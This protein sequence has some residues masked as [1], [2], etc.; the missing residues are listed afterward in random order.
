MLNRS[1]ARCVDARA[2]GA[3]EGTRVVLRHHTPAVHWLSKQATRCAGLLGLRA[4]AALA[5][6]GSTAAVGQLTNV[7]TLRR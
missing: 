7:R 1:R 4:A 5:K 2:D 3:K 6:K